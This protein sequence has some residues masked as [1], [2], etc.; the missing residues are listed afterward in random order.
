MVFMCIQRNFIALQI[1][2]GLTDVF[3]V[4][5]LPKEKPYLQRGEVY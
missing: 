1:S 3:N 5:L 2:G 4:S